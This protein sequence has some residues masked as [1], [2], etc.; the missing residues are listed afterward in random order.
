MTRRTKV[1]ENLNQAE[2]DRF[3]AHNEAFNSTIMTK[4][5]QFIQKL[6]GYTPKMEKQVSRII[7]SAAKIHAG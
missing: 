6:P 7:T 5:E 2:Q 3:E 4:V 1:Y